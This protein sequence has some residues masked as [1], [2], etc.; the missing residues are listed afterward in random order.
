MAVAERAECF[1]DTFDR[2]PF[3]FYESLRARGDV[4]WDE[5]MEAWLI[6]SAGVAREV[7]RDERRFAFPYGTMRGAGPTFLKLRANNPRSLKFLSGDEH[8]RMHRWWVRELLAPKWV[9]RY[10]AQLIRPS[11][12]RLLDELEPRGHA[13]LVE[14]FAERLPLLV[15]SGLLGLPWDDDELIGRVKRLNDTYGLGTEILQSMRLADA[16][17]DPAHVAIVDRAVDASEELN[18]MLVP[19]IEAR[20]DG[21]GEDFISRLWAGGSAI[22]DGWGDVDMLD[23]CRLLLFAGIDTTTH[24]LANGFHRVLTMPGLAQELRGE[25]PVAIFAE[26]LLRLD[27][28]VHY[29]PRQ[30]AVDVRLGG[31]EVK[32]G[33]M[34]MV[35]LLAAN[36]DPARHGC[37]HAVDLERPAPRDHLAFSYGARAC[38][39][40]A[41][42]RAELVDAFELALARFPSMELDGNAPPP[43]YKG[44]LMRSHRP[45]N[46]RL[47]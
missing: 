39:G 29:R 6:V 1:W 24:A 11:V 13:E 3:D 31:A 34:L 15:F 21:E 32:Q 8:A 38:P 12:Q 2:V 26:E 16:A 14:D 36:R 20:R 30:A 22:L 10:R 45:L 9:E 42:A 19:L 4:V 47:A 27:G 7:L 35:L 18:R 17:P 28:S 43:G 23:A 37:P 5:E 25:G 40:A 46:V 44:F 33:D 41:L